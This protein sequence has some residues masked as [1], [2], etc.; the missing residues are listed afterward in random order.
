M[1]LCWIPLHRLWLVS[2][3]PPY[4]DLSFTLCMSLSLLLSSKLTPDLI[5]LTHLFI[6]GDS[7]VSPCADHLAGVTVFL[8]SSTSYTLLT[9]L[10]MSAMLIS[11]VCLSLLACYLSQCLFSIFLLT[12]GVKCVLGSSSTQACENWGCFLGRQIGM[13]QVGETR[14]LEPSLNHS[15]QLGGTTPSRWLLV[16]LLASA[17]GS[18]LWV[19]GGRGKVLGQRSPPAGID[20]NSS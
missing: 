19:L 8:M 12:S 16:L 1:P 18:N 13:F 14:M 4:L 3:C 20:I 6:F 7:H 9:S 5:F 11:C 2:L 17:S 15:L 10:G